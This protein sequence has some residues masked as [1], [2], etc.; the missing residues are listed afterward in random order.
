MES[1]TEEECLSLLV[2]EELK[3]RKEAQE[4]FQ[5]EEEKMIQDCHVFY[6]NPEPKQ[7]VIC[8]PG[9]MGDGAVFAKQ[10]YANTEWSDTVFIGPTPFGYAWYPMPHDA[11]NQKQAL[12]GI[13]RAIKAIEAVQT[14]VEKRFGIPKSKTVLTGFSAGGV[15]AIQTATHSQ[16]EPYA[17]VVCHSGAILDPYSLNP[18]NCDTPF[19][20]TH[21][22]D[23]MCFEWF[24]RYLPMK[25]SLLSKG[26]NTFTLE[27]KLG[28]HYVSN[29]DY[30]QSAKFMVD[31][32][33]FDESLDE[34]RLYINS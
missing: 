15:M 8:I 9:R 21:N 23:D 29:E 28:G 10:H 25:N 20:L 19:L 3:A 26:Y 30:R 5:I 22:R 33:S 7:A 17:G 14:A 2:E 13:P 32:A 16:D 27:R 18:A 4:E 24:E 31:Y 1:M 34:E 6:K 12:N 11:N